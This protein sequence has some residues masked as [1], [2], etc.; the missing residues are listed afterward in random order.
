VTMHT[1]HRHRSPG[2]TRAVHHTGRPCSKCGKRTMSAN[3]ICDS[4]SV[5]IGGDIERLYHSREWKRVS[6][7]VMIRD[8]YK[9]QQCGGLARIVHHI[10]PVRLN[11]ERFFGS[12][13]CIALCVE[14]HDVIHGRKR[15]GGA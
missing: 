14:C 12:G 2:A 13:N 10:L 7:Y 11:P 9:C 6:K 4:C 8:M 15:E 1:N 5:G 3:R